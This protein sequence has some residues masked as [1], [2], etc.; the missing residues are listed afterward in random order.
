MFEK[1]CL[2]EMFERNVFMCL[3]IF[4]LTGQNLQIIWGGCGWVVGRGG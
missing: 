4:F 1:I 3:N 2:K